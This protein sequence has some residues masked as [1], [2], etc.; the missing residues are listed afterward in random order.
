MTTRDMKK[1]NKQWVMSFGTLLQKMHLIDNNKE[2]K[3]RES[4]AA[5]FHTIIPCATKSPIEAQFLH[6]H[7]HVKFREVQVQ[8]RGKVNC[9]TRSIEFALGFT[10]YEVLN[11]KFN[12]FVVT[13]DAISCEVKCQCLLFESRGFL[14]RHCLSALSFKR[15]DKVAP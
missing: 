10:T 8:F 11:S 1:F 3:E 7:T 13:Y 15:V 2:Q 9:I 6:V 12:K 4:D 5:D 14:Y